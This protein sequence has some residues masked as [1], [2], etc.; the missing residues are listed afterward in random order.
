MGSTRIHSVQ[1][2]STCP[3]VWNKSSNHISCCTARD[4]IMDVSESSGYC[5]EV[6]NHYRSDPVQVQSTHCLGH[7][8][9]Y[10][11]ARIWP[12]GCQPPAATGSCTQGAAGL[13]HNALH[14]PMQASC[15]LSTLLRHTRGGVLNSCAMHPPDPPR[16]RVMT[17]A[18]FGVSIVRIR[19]R[20]HYLR[21]RGLV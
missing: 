2:G 9:W 6:C 19:S 7:Q 12:S 11:R 10:A 3:C 5:P 8:R 16:P 20:I 1:P 18:G 14:N 4:I 13:G 15:W 17:N 21:P